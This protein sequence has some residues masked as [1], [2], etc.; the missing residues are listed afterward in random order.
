MR[1]RGRST[2]AW[3]VVPVVLGVGVV[4]AKRWSRG[5]PLVAGVHSG[6][7]GV[8]H[9]VPW[10]L[11]TTQGRERPSGAGSPVAVQNV[12]EYDSQASQSRGDSSLSPLWSAGRPV[13]T[14]SAGAPEG[15]SSEV[16]QV[17]VDL[18]HAAMGGAT[19][20]LDA[21]FA[22]APHAVGRVPTH[23]GVHVGAEQRVTV[24]GGGALPAEL[25]ELVQQMGPGRWEVDLRYRGLIVI[26]EEAP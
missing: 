10:P 13:P 8:T 9:R 20:E 16:L 19:S 25:V 23:H 11:A 18:N 7:A 12:G 24:R 1:A 2:A 21:E 22:Q 15:A 14:V 26:R 4:G 5:D 3:L 6:A 17:D